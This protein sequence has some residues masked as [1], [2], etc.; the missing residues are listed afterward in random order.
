MSDDTKAKPLFEEAL[1]IRLKVLGRDHPDT[2]ESL[3]NLAV[4]Y[5]NMGEYAKGEPLLREALE[6]RQK[7]LGPEHPLTASSLNNLAFLE[8]DSD[9]LEEGR[10]L[11]QL[12]YGVDLKIFSQILSFGS[13][14]QRLA[15]QSL[16]W[17][18]YCGQA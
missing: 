12:A 10:R 15:Y 18:R 7:L 8:I 9:H 17:D 4:I 11:A 1:E 13:E 16:G 3:N 6:I 2:A 5:E 14:G